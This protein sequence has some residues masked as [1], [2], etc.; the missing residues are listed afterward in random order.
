MSVF[1]RRHNYLRAQGIQA[2]QRADRLQAAL[3]ILTRSQQL[4][5]RLDRGFVGAVDEQ[6]LRGVSLP[7]IGAV[8]SSDE[9][10]GF[11]AVQAGSLAEEGILGIDAVKAAFV[12]ARAQI[13]SFLN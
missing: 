3:G 8:E 10:R 9:P 11:E 4:F 7:S 12:I 6:S 2:I 13:K 5:E 1:Q